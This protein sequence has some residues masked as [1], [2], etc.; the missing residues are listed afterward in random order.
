MTDEQRY[1]CVE[2]LQDIKTERFITNKDL[3]D[4]VGISHSN[5]CRIFSHDYA[6][7]FERICELAGAMGY[8]VI[9]HMDGSL[10]FIQEDD[11]GY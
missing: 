4:A 1:E 5:I 11:Y 9:H 2:R 8:G 3:S 6:C 7:S 10:N